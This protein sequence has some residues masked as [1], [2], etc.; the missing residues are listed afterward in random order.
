[1]NP[2]IFREAIRDLRGGIYNPG[3]QV[4]VFVNGV[5]RPAQIQ[6]LASYT[7]RQL[8]GTQQRADIPPNEVFVR[9]PTQIFDNGNIVQPV[10]NTTIMNGAPVFYRPENDYVRIAGIII[11]RNYNIEIDGVTS[12]VPDTSLRRPAQAQAAQPQVQPQAQA[13][14]AQPQPQPQP[15]PQAQAQQGIFTANQRVEVEDNG[16]WRPGIVIGLNTQTVSD[17]ATGTIYTRDRVR[18]RPE[19]NARGSLLDLNRGNSNIMRPGSR[20]EFQQDNSWDHVL[21]GTLVSNNYF[22]SVDNDSMRTFPNTRIRLSTQ[23][24]A[25]PLQLAQPVVRPAQLAQPVVRPAQ[26][27]PRP[28]GVA[29]EIH[30]AFPELNFRRFM[31]IVK[32]DNNGASNFK[33]STYPL[34]PLITYINNDTSTTIVDTEIERDGKKIQ[35]PEKTDTIRDLNDRIKDQINAYLSTH[36]ES[37]DN[38]MEMIQFVMSQ[39]VDYKDP[40]IRFLV[41]DCMNAYRKDPRNPN[42]GASCAKGMFERVF[43]TNKS[44]LIPL[45]SDDTSSSASSSASSSSASESSSSSCKPVYRELLGCFYPDMDLNALFHE[46]YAINN[47]EEGS[48]SPLANASEEERKE[49]FRRFVLSKVPRAD[50]TAINNYIER[51]ENTF[52]TLLIGG[53]RKRRNRKTKRKSLRKG[54]GKTVKKDKRKTKRRY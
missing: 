13:A 7:V 29:F 34:Q 6:N 39:G 3:Q 4:E 5:W 8:L 19:M 27:A 28:A 54:K 37:R 20:V 23:P 40:Y 38:V 32:R 51:N 36:P 43:L 18:V 16:V 52:K 21:R 11:S 1:M 9:Q 44:V 33:D 22:V 53:R 10:D 12:T 26:P 41:F 47:L 14:Q 42:S 50:S 15:Q 25:R 31:D 46:W 24:L 49:D 35:I 48:T 45:C 30:N 17:T 2:S